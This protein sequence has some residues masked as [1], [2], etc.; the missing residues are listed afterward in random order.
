MMMTKE[1][2]NAVDIE[3]LVVK[4]LIYEKFFNAHVVNTPRNNDSI[5]IWKIV[6]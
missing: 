3:I 6:Y 2:S 4:K 1:I 5:R